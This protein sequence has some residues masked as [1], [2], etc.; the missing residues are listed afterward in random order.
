MGTLKMTSSIVHNLAENRFEYR[1]E[2]AIA[3]CEYKPHGNIW[4][5]NH[6]VVPDSMR[7]QGIAARLVE[8]ALHYVEEHNLKVVPNCS[9]V[10]AFIQKKPEYTRLIAK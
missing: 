2:D 4:H 8:T 6:T 10:A 5:F 3:V 9:Y 1:A 7:S